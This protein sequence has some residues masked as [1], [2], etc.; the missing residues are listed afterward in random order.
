MQSCSR[1][2]DSCEPSPR[3]LAPAPEVS[4]FSEHAS[5]AQESPEDAP[6]RCRGYL[7]CTRGAPG[8]RGFPRALGGA[9]FLPAGRFK[10]GGHCEGTC[11]A[12]GASRP[13]PLLSPAGETGFP[14]LPDFPG[15]GAALFGFGREQR[16]ST[17]MASRPSSSCEQG[18]HLPRDPLCLPE[19]PCFSRGGHSASSPSFLTLSPGCIYSPVHSQCKK[20]EMSQF[21]LPPSQHP[22]K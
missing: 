10:R 20:K 2:R 9:L 1:V 18:H 15:F 3:G 21:S 6:E 17:C 11:A 14:T 13:R 22:P 5:S 8:P 12:R 7:G 16:T 19:K 4:T